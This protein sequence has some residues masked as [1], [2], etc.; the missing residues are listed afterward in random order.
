MERSPDEPA[1]KFRD[2]KLAPGLRTFSDLERFNEP[3]GPRSC[4]RIK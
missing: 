4:P 3:D 1:L 2:L